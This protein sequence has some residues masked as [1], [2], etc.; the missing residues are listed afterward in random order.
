ME[1]RLENTFNPFANS[2]VI[3]IYV[4]AGGGS[5]ER[6]TSIFQ[7]SKLVMSYNSMPGMSLDRQTHR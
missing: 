4:C 3:Y 7:I 2:T 6:H 1:D 5:E